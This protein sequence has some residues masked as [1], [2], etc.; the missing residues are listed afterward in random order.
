M[1]YLNNQQNQKFAKEQI[2]NLVKENLASL[3]PEQE[4]WKVYNRYNWLS[5]LYNYVVQREQD[6]IV[7]R[8]VVEVNT[9]TLA[10]SES[11]RNLE[12][13]ADRLADD[14]S[15]VIEKI[16][17]ANSDNTVFESKDLKYISLNQLLTTK[18]GNSEENMLVA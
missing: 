1:T 3:Y 17:V 12:M 8:V 16:L 10:D 6:G 7:E 15:K 5:Y 14:Q 18:F 2:S 11:V 4:G 13:L 9:H